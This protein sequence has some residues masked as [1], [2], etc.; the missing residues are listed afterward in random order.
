MI[1]G[2]GNTYEAALQQLKTYVQEHSMRYSSVREMVLEHICNLPQPFTAEQL[3]RACQ[4]DRISV[5][6]IYNTLT[7]FVSARI[8]HEIERQHGHT[9]S[10]YS[11]IQDRSVRMQ[12]ICAKCQRISSF[13]DKA[14]EHLVMN[15]VYSNFNADHIAIYVYGECKHCRNKKKEDNL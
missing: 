1:K 14:I 3:V 4:E 11:I 12:I 15:R 2:K 5:G 6:T 13:R 9:R 10:E 7:L 8:L